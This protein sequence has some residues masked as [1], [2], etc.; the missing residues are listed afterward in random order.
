MMGKKKI[1]I[2]QWQLVGLIVIL[3]V[4][5][6]LYDLLYKHHLEQTAALFIGLPAFLAIAVTLTPKAK[7]TTGMI[8]K[9]MT[10]A[11]LLSGILL[12]EGFICIIMAAPIAYLVGGIIGF[13]IDETRARRGDSSDHTRL[14]GI[15]LAITLVFSLEGVHPTL[16][17]P[18]NETV[19]T[20]R[21][22]TASPDEIEQAL[23]QT[24]RFAGILPFFLR[25][26]FPKPAEVETEGLAVGDQWRV[27]FGGP[28]GFYGE[29]PS[30]DLIMVVEGRTENRIRFRVISDT[31][32]IRHWLKWQASEVRWAAVSPTETQVTWTFYYE[33]QL[34]P[35]WY[36]SPWERYAVGLAGSYLID[37]LA[38]PLP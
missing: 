16:S 5:S 38:T 25:L 30:G 32:H 22:V 18:N 17:W 6:I 12:R 13:V 28:A 20:E 11:L 21:V 19:R 4:G 10:I 1:S 35:A 15:V 29:G 23:H 7:S 9:G 34:A 37:S 33:R 8:M 36:F 14:Y 2:F 27:H 24:P 26:G 3:A 31:S